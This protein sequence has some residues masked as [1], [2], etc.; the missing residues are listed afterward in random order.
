MKRLI[1]IAAAIFLGFSA[2]AQSNWYVGGAFNVSGASYSDPEIVIAPVVG[3]SLSDTW[4]LGLSMSFASEAVP[5]GVSLDPFVRYNCASLG[6]NVNFFVDGIL[7]L[8]FNY[9]DS[10]K[11]GYGLRIRP[12]FAFSLSDKVALATHLGDFSF[13]NID[14][15]SSWNAGLDGNALSLGFYFFL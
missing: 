14:G 5:A 2:N 7:P 9:M 4:G 10:G 8:R 1:I 6:K 3:C 13:F 11:F 15:N 12:G